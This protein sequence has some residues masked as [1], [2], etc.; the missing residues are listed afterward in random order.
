M[1]FE[2]GTALF[3]LVGIVSLFMSVV[4]GGVIEESVLSTLE[5]NWLRLFNGI[6]FLDSASIP[7]VSKLGRP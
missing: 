2:E 1:T 5:L 3:K 4:G 6:V 7:W